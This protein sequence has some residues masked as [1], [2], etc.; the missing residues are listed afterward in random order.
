M[1]QYKFPETI[2]VEK[3]ASKQNPHIVLADYSIIKA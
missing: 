3:Q 2:E 1:T